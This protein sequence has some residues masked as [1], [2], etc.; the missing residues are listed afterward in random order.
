MHH[1]FQQRQKTVV[2][3]AFSGLS[4]TPLD[5]A[6]VNQNGT[7]TTY[8]NWPD[9]NPRISRRD[10][11]EVPTRRSPARNQHRP[12]Q[13]RF[14]CQSGTYSNGSGTQAPTAFG[15]KIVSSSTPITYAPSGSSAAYVGQLGAF[16][17]NG[18]SAT[19]FHG[20]SSIG[21]ANEGLFC[22][23]GR[24]LFLSQGARWRVARPWQ[25]R[26]PRRLVPSRKTWLSRSATAP[27]LAM[28]RCNLTPRTR[29]TVRDTIP[30]AGHPRQRDLPKW[31]TSQTG[32]T[33]GHF[34]TISHVAD[35]SSAITPNP[36]LRASAQP[37]GAIY[38]PGDV[39]GRE[40]TTLSRP[41]RSH[42]ISARGPLI[43]VCRQ[44]RPPDNTGVLCR[45]GLLQHWTVAPFISA[46]GISAPLRLILNGFAHPVT[47]HAD[48]GKMRRVGQY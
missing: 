13:R 15:Y 47:L 37:N 12:Q 32:G 20:L 24:H 48:G 46:L 33:A 42:T 29:I 4:A 8:N 35:G 10:Q 21:P 23:S 14:V 18:T 9:G 27:W 19:T 7:S 45:P 38:L 41:P 34:N 36:L 3:A 11:W 40:L 39:R 28:A 26:K 6:S 22:I 1:E 5:A 31:S 16:I 44:Y 30:G 2:A 25:W 17:G 43:T